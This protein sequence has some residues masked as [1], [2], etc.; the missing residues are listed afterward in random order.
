MPNKENKVHFDL[1]N[2]HF[3]PLTIE[4]G[5]VSFGTPVREYGAISMDLP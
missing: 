2:V 5:V 4:D 3:A 1:T